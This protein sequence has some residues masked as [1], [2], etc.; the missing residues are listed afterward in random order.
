MKENNEHH[1]AVPAPWA[2]CASKA[3]P[4]LLALLLAIALA[5]CGKLKAQSC[6]W[7][8]VLH[9]NEQITYELYFKWGILMPKAGVAQF[10]T[11]NTSYDNHPA[12]KYQMFFRTTGMFDKIFKMRDTLATYFTPEQQLLFSDKR[13]EEGGYYL[14]DL[15][16]FSPLPG[17]TSVR[18]QRYGRTGIKF[19][20]TLVVTGCAWDMM[21]TTLYLRTIAWDKLKTKQEFPFRVAVGKD[22]VNAAFRYDGQAIVSPDEQVKYRTHHFYIDVYDPA[23]EQSKEA[24]EVWVSDDENHLP[25]RVRAKLKIGAAEVYFKEAVNLKHPFGSRIFITGK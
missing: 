1:P 15:M 13:T 4:S 14:A 20:T 17:K 23:F 2:V 5:Y 21:A 22:I 6:E 3:Y 19:D 24:A 11:Q 9:H 16:W 7:P 12:W 25:I 18:S 10:S 8:P